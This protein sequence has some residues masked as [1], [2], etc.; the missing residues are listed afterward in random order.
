MIFLISYDRQTQSLMRPVESFTEDERAE[1]RRRRFE[2]QLALPEEQ[3]RY[4]VV[5][6]EASSDR[7]IRQTHA[8]FR[9]ERTAFKCR[10]KGG[11][12]KNVRATGRT[13][14]F[15]APAKGV[16]AGRRCGASGPH[17]TFVA[18]VNRAA[19]V[20]YRLRVGSEPVA[21]GHRIDLSTA[22]PCSRALGDRLS[23]G[24]H[25]ACCTGS[26]HPGNQTCDLV[27][28]RRSL[29]SEGEFTE[30]AF[31]RAIGFGRVAADVVGRAWSGRDG[32]AL[33]FLT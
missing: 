15:E 22:G 32:V 12:K 27:N 3:G 31:R 7:D 33:L 28:R 13:P 5:L 9:L 21:P 19:I 30:P 1:A 8:L 11:R 6:L 25:H 14:A 18:G 26:W 24:A 2:V 20:K 10:R 23:T 4:E 29:D 17:S 16:T